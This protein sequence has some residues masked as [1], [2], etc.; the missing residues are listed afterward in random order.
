MLNKITTRRV[1]HRVMRLLEPH[2]SSRGVWG[3]VNGRAILGDLPS[4]VPRGFV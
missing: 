2:F 3:V 1:T 4:G